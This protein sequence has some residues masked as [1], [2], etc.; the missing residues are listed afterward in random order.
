MLCRIPRRRRMPV[1]TRKTC[2]Q[3]GENKEKK[4]VAVSRPRSVPEAACFRAERIDRL[5]VSHMFEF[6]LKKIQY[7][8]NKRSI[9]FGIVFVQF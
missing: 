5:A 6:Q 1:Y 4:S 7:I 3:E 8:F 2:V 9:D